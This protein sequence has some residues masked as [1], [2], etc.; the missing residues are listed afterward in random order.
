MKMRELAQLGAAQRVKEI[1]AEL[2]EIRKAFPGIGAELRA[3]RRVESGS[4][5]GG[6]GG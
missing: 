4:G 5:G 2:A 3:G 6:S 1:E